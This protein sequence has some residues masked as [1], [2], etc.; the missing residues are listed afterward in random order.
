MANTSAKKRARK[1]RAASGADSGKPC[2]T[3]RGADFLKDANMSDDDSDCS[4]SVKFD[5]RFSDE[6]EL[7][8]QIIALIDARIEQL[9]RNFNNAL[10][11][12]NI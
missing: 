11:R 6:N 3:Q 12:S 9:R 4:A 1:R 2:K 7:S 10:S 5:G 8:P